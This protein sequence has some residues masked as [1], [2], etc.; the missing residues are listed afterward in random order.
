[1]WPRQTRSL[2]KRYIFLQGRIQD[3]FQEGVHSS[4]ALLQHQSTTWFFFFLQNTNCIRKRQ[5]IS[6]GGGVHPLHPPPRSAPVLVVISRAVLSQ[7]VR[8]K[9]EERKYPSV[10]L[11]YKC[12]VNKMKTFLRMLQCFYSK[13]IIRQP[14][15]IVQQLGYFISLAN[16]QMALK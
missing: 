6:G 16:K 15:W 13:Q 11:K 5:V 1:M 3:F 14:S 4:V 9:G 12:Y 7:F 8:N 2:K 10:I